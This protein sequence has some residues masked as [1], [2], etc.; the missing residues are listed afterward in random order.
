MSPGA[1][2]SIQPLAIAAA[3]ALM[4]SLLARGALLALRCTVKAFSRCSVAEACLIALMPT[5]FAAALTVTCTQ[6]KLG[7]RPRLSHLQWFST[8][9]QA[10]KAPVHYFCLWVC[11]D[12]ACGAPA[13]KHPESSIMGTVP[14]RLQQ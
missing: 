10:V 6:H 4:S 5:S 7:C 3:A 9:H 1:C 12:E 11:P 14:E 8:Q 2:G 13:V